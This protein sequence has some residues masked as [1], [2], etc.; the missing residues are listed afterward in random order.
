MLHGEGE[1]TVILTVWERRRRRLH[2]LL[3][4]RE[5]PPAGRLQGR[6]LRESSGL[7]G[8]LSVLL[9]GCCLW[10]DGMASGW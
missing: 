3:L 8:L 10:L 4:A 1:L 2:G 5:L 7:R 6:D 9:S